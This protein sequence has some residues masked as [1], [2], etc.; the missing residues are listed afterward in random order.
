MDCVTATKI[1]DCGGRAERRHRFS[2]DGWHPKAAWRYAFRRR[3][4]GRSFL[5]VYFVCFAVHQ[6][7]QDSACI[8]PVSRAS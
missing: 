6:F 7:V 4:N 8:A 1:L 2:H 3:P 5:F